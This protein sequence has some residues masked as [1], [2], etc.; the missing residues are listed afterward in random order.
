MSEDNKGPVINYREGGK[1]NFTPTKKMG[2]GG[3]SFSHTEEGRK[4]FPPSK[5]G[6]GGTLS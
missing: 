6:G 3:K 2:G 1:Y 5:M 4:K